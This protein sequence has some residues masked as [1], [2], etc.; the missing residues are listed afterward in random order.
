MSRPSLLVLTAALALVLLTP[1][2]GCPTSPEPDDDDAADDDDGGGPDPAP[3]NDAGDEAFVRRVVPLMWGRAP[4]SIREV[5]VLVDLVSASDRESVVRAMAT[6]P[7]FLDHWHANL[8]DWTS[9][10]RIGIRANIACYGEP[11][12][13]SDSPDLAM[14]VRDN[15]ALGSDFGEAWNL[16]DLARS[17][18][19][20]D[21]LSP[22]FEADL[23]AM[24]AW[25]APLMNI[26]ETE[27]ARANIASAFARNYL[28]RELDCL[29]CHN[30]AASVTGHPEPDLDRTWEVPGHWELALFGDSEGLA[31]KGDLHIFFRRDGVTT[32]PMPAVPGESH[33]PFFDPDTT[34]PW[35]MHEDC[36]TWAVPD[37]VETDRLGFSGTFAGDVG[38]AASMWDMEPVFHAGLDALRGDVPTVGDD[39]TV[40]GAE[41]AAWMLAMSV[42]EK[43]WYQAFGSGLTVSHNFPR[44]RAQ[45]DLLASL[46]ESWTT[47]GYSL[48]ELL[49]AITAHPYFVQ[50]APVDVVETHN[51]YYLDPIF[52]PFSDAN[53]VEEARLN[54]VGDALE[55]K[56]P[57]VLLGSAY[58][59]L[60]W[61]RLPTFPEPFVPLGPD[62]NV[63]EYD[64]GA[65][66]QQSI[67][68][69]M[70][71]S[72]SGFRSQDFQTL[73]AW[74]YW[75]GACTDSY[76]GN[77]D[78]DWVDGLLTH[79]ADEEATVSGALLA[80]KDRL[81]SDPTFADDEADIVQA[82]LGD[83]S[84]D[85]TVD[86]SSDVEDAIRRMC[87]VWLS[88][89]QF[90]LWGDPGEPR[91]GAGPDLVVPGSSYLELC[92]ATSDSLYGGG[93]SCSEDSL[94]IE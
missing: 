71:H 66:I 18:I 7:E 25:D 79:A 23:Y 73:L 4:A 49:V 46:S 43:A 92:E 11:R 1:L 16:W 94:E 20:L 64:D 27:A 52:D 33:P 2:A 76:D 40:D 24:V 84:L 3:V 93:V 6:S 22:Y 86:D 67:G 89:P 88:S 90:Q 83:V 87:G 68:L 21:D 26:F 29:P 75:F 63:L 82:V 69:S 34:F 9:V 62:N 47:S 60:G 58:A 13:G 35:G 38:D 74:E 15:P 85:A 19:V 78:G 55:R 14:Y 70:K 39:H 12:L 81:L 80:L 10:S 77:D 31:S 61:E 8:F 50:N 72:S 32:G 28:H 53:I 37:Q 54:S 59:A 44:T 42:A 48:V 36:G 57:R 30:S 45:R 65:W 56:P 5:E 51:P 91:V 17:A 41:A